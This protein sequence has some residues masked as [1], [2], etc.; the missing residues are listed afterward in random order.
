V[1][2][3]TKCIW[4]RKTSEVRK[5]LIKKSDDAVVVRC[6]ALNMHDDPVNQFLLS[7]FPF[8]YI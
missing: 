4:L 2:K 1:I 8:V 7:L 5:V 6:G 3:E